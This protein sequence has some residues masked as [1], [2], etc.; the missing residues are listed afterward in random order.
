MSQPPSLTLEALVADLLDALY[1]GCLPKSDLLDGLPDTA[2]AICWRWLREAVLPALAHREAL[3]VSHQIDPIPV[4][5]HL[6]QP[7]LDI[8]RLASQPPDNLHRLG[9]LEGLVAVEAL[10]VFIYCPAR[11][12]EALALLRDQAVRLGHLCAEWGRRTW[13]G[14]GIYLLAG[15]MRLLRYRASRVLA[16]FLWGE[17]A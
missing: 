2:R 6:G 15:D 5:R 10:E 8:S 3:L 7:S 17:A 13:P 12:A 14:V 4:L 16:P 11:Q 9:R 1:T